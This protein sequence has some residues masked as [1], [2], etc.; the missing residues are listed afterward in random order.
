MNQAHYSFFTNNIAI[1]ITNN[2][3]SKNIFLL[4]FS[5][6]MLKP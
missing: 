5:F 6:V 4:N 1:N 2:I 3:N